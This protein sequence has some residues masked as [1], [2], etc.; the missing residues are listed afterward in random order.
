MVVSRRRRNCALLEK[1]RS[2]KGFT[3]LEMLIVMV[4]VSLVGL[5]IFS[6]LNN[7]IKIWQR[8]NQIVEQE[9]INIFFERL[10]QEM[11]N[12]FEFALIGFRG[13]RDK[14]TFAALV[15]SKNLGCV[16]TGTV[17][18][19]VYVY[20]ESSKRLTKEERDY[21]QI[22]KGDSGRK[23]HLLEN[24]DSL[25]FSYYFYDSTTEEFI[26]LDEWEEEDLPLAI[27]VELELYDGQ[28]SKAI[29]RTIDIPISQYQFPP[30]S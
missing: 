10:T 22:Y 1:P 8:L 15:T 11:C 24:I 18:E 26:W 5:V 3:L 17:G 23:R 2:L 12:T 6:T 7:G 16:Q 9:D 27:R 29:T 14:F 19:I 28:K 21:S 30:Q 4:L 13:A 20:D 25:K